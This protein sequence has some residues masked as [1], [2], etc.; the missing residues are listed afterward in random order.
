M[1]HSIQ[2][3][4]DGN[5]TSSENVKGFPSELITNSKEKKPLT[6]QDGVTKKIRDALCEFLVLVTIDGCGY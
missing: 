3:D 4:C 6:P 2:H 1:Y 5:S